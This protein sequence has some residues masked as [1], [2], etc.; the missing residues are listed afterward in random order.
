MWDSAPIPST[1]IGW[2]DYPLFGIAANG[3]ALYES[4]MFKHIDKI[5]SFFAKIAVILATVSLLL[6]SA[7][8]ETGHAGLSVD[9]VSHFHVDQDHDCTEHTSTELNSDEATDETDC[10]TPA[11]AHFMILVSPAS[12]AQIHG[13]PWYFSTHASLSSTFPPEDRRPPIL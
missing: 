2:A 13:K 1:P 8:L 12:L 3:V 10:H 5:G 7:I 4:R 11:H 6:N 9:L